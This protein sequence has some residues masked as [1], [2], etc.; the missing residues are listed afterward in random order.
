MHERLR[1]VRSSPSRQVSERML[2]TYLD[3][4]FPEHHQRGG[5]PQRLSPGHTRKPPR[6]LPHKQGEGGVLVVPHALGGG[7]R[8]AS[9][10]L[11][12]MPNNADAYLF[13]RTYFAS[14][15]RGDGG[16]K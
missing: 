4:G 10:E 12:T 5:E 8:T 14:P 1:S 6:L 11:A 7:G 16:P 13:Y 3:P 15:K 2:F 9:E